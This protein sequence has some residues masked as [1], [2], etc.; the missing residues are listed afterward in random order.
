MSRK[1]TRRGNNEGSIY[2]RPDGRW[3]GQVTIGY[4][5]NGK[6][7]RKTFYGTT[8][9]EVA[10]KVTNV[11]SDHFRGI[12]F[13]EPQNITVYQLVNDWL[14]SFKK[15]SVTTRT[16]EWYLTNAKTHIYRELGDLPV[17]K[18]TTYHIQ[19][20]LN[21]RIN[22]GLKLRTLKVIQSIFNQA[23]KHACEMN[24]LAVNPAAS[25]KIPKRERDI[26]EKV[27]AIP[28]ALRKQILDAAGQES[29][30]K[31]AIT[32][33][34][35]TGM[36]IG[37]FLALPWKN[38]DFKN[39]II[40]VDRAITQDSDYDSN[41][42]R[43]SQ[44]TIISVPK[45]YSG[46]RKIKVSDVVIDTLQEWRALQISKSI[47]FAA[48]E[49]IVFSNQKGGNY[50]YGGFRANYRRFVK[51]HGFPQ[52]ISLHCYRHTFATMMLESGINPRVV[53]KILGHKDIV[54]TLGIYSHVLQ[55]VYDEA[56]ETAQKIYC[57]FTAN[58]SKKGGFNR[59][60]AVQEK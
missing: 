24:L 42:V 21:T 28:V 27:K 44:N 3:C 59:A 16:F 8:R 17:Q 12:S 15:P 19:T 37:K 60:K 48:N 6:P 43:I 2:Q 54:T 58:G 46:N 36:R 38:V 45:T 33:L 14:F 53:Q 31:T 9:E 11:S 5:P 35:F 1:N 30:M 55:E 7:N 25:T 10:E 32:T 52:D 23:L 26:D 50:T 22:E 20:L 40:T 29:A 39:K 4:K 47:A 34:M 18:L 56:A 51:K 49:A 13:I 41:G 57:N